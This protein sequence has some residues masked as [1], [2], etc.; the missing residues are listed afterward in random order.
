MGE[1]FALI[2]AVIW[3]SAVILFKKSGETISPLNLNLFRVGVSCVLFT[4]TLT[5][6]DEPL[7]GRAPLTDYLILFAKLVLIDHGRVPFVPFIRRQFFSCED[8][9]LSL[10][11]VLLLLRCHLR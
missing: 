9:G 11:Q 5:I 8:R 3:A 4:I 10:G 6:L 2:A 7:W 1:V